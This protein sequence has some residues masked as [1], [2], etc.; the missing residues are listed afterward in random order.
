MLAE[1]DLPEYSQLVP[2]LILPVVVE[3]AAV[4]SETEEPSL[5]LPVVEEL[6]SGTPVAEQVEM[7]PSAMGSGLPPPHGFPP[8]VW[9]VDDGG[10][11]R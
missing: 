6:N 5:I 8:F 3:E 1:E 7:E 2:P 9:P 10:D 11:G 4:V